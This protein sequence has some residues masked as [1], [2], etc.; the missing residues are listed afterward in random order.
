VPLSAAQ[1]KQ[2]E[3]LGANVRRQRNR[4]GITQEALAELTEVNPRTV[5][6]IEAGDI[7]VL[8]TTIIRVK[9]ALRCRWDELMP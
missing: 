3:K 4:A 9:H 7:N 8:V 1:K 6:K 5:Q 2:L